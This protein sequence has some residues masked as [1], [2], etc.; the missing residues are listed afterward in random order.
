MASSVS[1]W[2]DVTSASSTAGSTAATTTAANTEASVEQTFMSLLVAQ[3]KNQNPLS[4]TDSVEFMSQLVQIN[5]LEQ[6]LGIRDDLSVI[7][8]SMTAET[9]AGTTADDSTGT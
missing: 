3:I 2:Y 5:Q 9:T 1:N 8:E 4:P 7:Y 6:I